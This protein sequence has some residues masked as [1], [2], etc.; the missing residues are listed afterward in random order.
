M[1]KRCLFFSL[2]FASTAFAQVPVTLTG[3]VYDKDNKVAALTRLMVIN[4][5]TNQ[6]IFA[7]PDGRFSITVFPA[8]TLTFSA[9]GYKVRSVCFKDSIVKSKLYVEVPLQQLQFELAEV[10]VFAPRSLSE[11]QKDIDKLGVKKTYT[12]TGVDA[13]SSPITALYERFSRF[14]QSKRKV[15]EWEN[16]DLKKDVLKDLFHLYVKYDIIDLKDD[17][18][19]DFI[20]YLNLSDDFIKNASEF[21]L[22]M[23]IKGKYENF[24][25]RWK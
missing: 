24:K 7:G 18:F 10:S 23:A 16:E 2:F 11:I 3:K 12:T 4:K 14:E 6:G 22:V 25:Y 9:L 19:D 13:F 8:D 15:A 5:R 1:K 21:E 17:E 20:K